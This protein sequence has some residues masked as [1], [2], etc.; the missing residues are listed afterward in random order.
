MV[1]LQERLAVQVVGVV[2][3]VPQTRRAIQQSPRPTVALERDI[4]R[5]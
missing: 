1:V 4:G 3:A 5:R 2:E